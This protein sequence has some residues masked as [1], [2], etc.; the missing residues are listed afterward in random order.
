[1]DELIGA[2]ADSKWPDEHIESM[3]FLRM[4]KYGSRF[5]GTKS[6]AQLMCAWVAVREEFNAIN[7][8]D[9]S[10]ERIKN[11][12]QS[13]KRKY[14]EIRASEGMSGNQTEKV[15]VY[16][17]H[18]PALVEFFGDLSGRGN[19]DYG[20][21]GP[22]SYQPVHPGLIGGRKNI[23][24]GSVIIQTKFMAEM[25]RQFPEVVMVDSTHNTNNA[26]YKL[27]S[28]M[29]CDARGRGQFVQHAI[30][31]TEKKA[32][33][34]LVINH[35][36]TTNSRHE[37]FRCVM[38]LTDEVAKARTYNINAFTSHEMKACLHKMIYAESQEEYTSE[39][40]ISCMSE[41]W[42][43]NPSLQIAFIC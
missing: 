26:K 40:K 36:K 8:T 11:K 29:V 25:F 18:W 30:V 31:L 20:Q 33:L 27:F 15:I 16:P 5:V 14:D 22:E 1:M 13:L 4:H 28:I 7:S 42:K 37:A 17:S 32:T 24:G 3:L 12:F 2:T 35:F 23:A 21:T 19:R 6:H 39:P 10:M 41:F 34:A 38:Y 9:Y 43:T